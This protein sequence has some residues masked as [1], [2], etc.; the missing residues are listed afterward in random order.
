MSL[1]SSK[2]FFAVVYVRIVDINECL[3]DNG[4]CEQ[5]CMDIDGSFECACN[6]GYRLAMN[7]RSCNGKDIMNKW[8]YLELCTLSFT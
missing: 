3:A 8:Y 5:N 7:N 6:S 1:T 4:G 2:L